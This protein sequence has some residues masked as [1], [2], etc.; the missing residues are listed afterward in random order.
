MSLVLCRPLW[1]D[2]SAPMVTHSVAQSAVYIDLQTAG[3]IDRLTRQVG[4]WPSLYISLCSPFANR[5]SCPTLGWLIV[6][7]AVRIDSQ[8]A[9]VYYRL[10]LCGV[11]YLTSRYTDQ[12]VCPSFRPKLLRKRMVGLMNRF[13]I[14]NINNR[15]CNCNPVFGSVMNQ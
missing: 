7:S 4:H 10:A 6:E 8:T 3:P 2:N 5:Y 11:T 12:Y 1:V 13:L 9:V 14:I 15:N